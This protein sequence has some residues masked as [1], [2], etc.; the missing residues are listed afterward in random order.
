MASF[1]LQKTHPIASD[2]NSITYDYKKK[3]DRSVETHKN[4]FCRD[5]ETINKIDQIIQVF[6]ASVFERMHF[7]G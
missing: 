1:K 4:V 5:A 6:E 2:F 3:R 7:G